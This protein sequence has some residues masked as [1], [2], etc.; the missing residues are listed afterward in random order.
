[1]TIADMELDKIDEEYQLVLEEQRK[2][3]EAIQWEEATA[4]AA[5]AEKKRKRQEEE[6]KRREEEDNKALLTQIGAL[7]ETQFAISANLT[8]MAST[9]QDYLTT[10]LI[11][12]LIQVNPLADIKGL[13]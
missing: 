12:M 6:K 13:F 8:S 11:L 4:K 2:K 1:M 9:F 10:S 5:F 3:H 7:A